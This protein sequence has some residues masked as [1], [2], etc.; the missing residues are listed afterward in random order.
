MILHNSVTISGLI[1]INMFRPLIILLSILL[2]I[3]YS[4]GFGQ[5]SVKLSKPRLEIKDS[6]L[7]ISYDILNSRQTEK[8]NIWIEATDSSGNKLAAKSLNGDIGENI[9]G[10]FNKNI[11]WNLGTDNIYIN[12]GIYIQ[13]Y[14]EIFKSAPINK[15]VHLLGRG[16][17]ISRSLFFPGWGLSRINPGKPHWLKGIA[18]YGCI[19][20]S[21]L[22]NMKA[23]STYDDYLTS[24]NI[25]M[26][27]SYF[28]DSVKENKLSKIFA[29]TAIGIWLTDFIW[30]VAG[31]S[32]LKNSTRPDKTVGFSI[33]PLYN[34][35]L[36][37]PGIAIKYDF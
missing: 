30:T 20:T 3:N 28:N 1:F 15:P 4:R 35:N 27:E 36:R 23:I 32:K 2:F 24:L 31:S 5:T 13:V 21:V 10:G 11:T 22:Y 25:K 16:G 14:A 29:F 12:I 17:V 34:Q 26:S 8:F 19:A 37:L 6:I 33:K 7:N 9:S 18:G